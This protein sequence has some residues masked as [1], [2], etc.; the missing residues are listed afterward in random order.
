ML[1]MS[2][3]LD[4]HPIRERLFVGTI[5]EEPR[6]LDVDLVVACYRLDVDEMSSRLACDVAA[7]P[8]LDDFQAMSPREVKAAEDAAAHAARVVAE[9]GSVLVACREGRNR[10]ALVAALACMGLDNLTAEEAIALVRERRI[11]PGLRV[12]SNEFFTEA[13]LRGDFEVPRQRE[14]SG[15]VYR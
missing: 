2:V 14:A 1:D 4:A 7:Y 6:P 11:L 12:L 10:S 8:F 9:G 15:A 3:R 13:L 5:A